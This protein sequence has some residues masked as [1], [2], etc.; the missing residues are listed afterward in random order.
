MASPKPIEPNPTNQCLIGLAQVLRKN[1]ANPGH[2]RIFIH[3]DTRTVGGTELGEIVCGTVVHI[4]NY[5]TSKKIGPARAHNP[6]NSIKP[7]ATN[8]LEMQNPAEFYV[9]DSKNP[10]LAFSAIHSRS[11]DVK[12]VFSGDPVNI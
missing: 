4:N 12:I 1:E 2:Q 10:L 9:P 3:R 7:L 5:L 11:P 6:A 8:F